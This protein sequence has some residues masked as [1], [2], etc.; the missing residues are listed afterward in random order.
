MIIRLYEDNPSPKHI[1]TIAKCLRDGGI[2]IYPTDT[3]YTFGCD[4]NKQKAIE[5][6]AKLK[7]VDPKKNNFSIVCESLSSASEFT[8]PI[9]NPTFKIMKRCLP[10]P[11]TFILNANSKLPKLFQ[12]KKKTVGIRIPNNAIVQDIIKELGNPILSASLHHKDKIIDY[13][14]DAELIYDEYKNK[15]DIVVNGGVGGNMPSTIVDCT[16]EENVIIREGLGDLSLI[17]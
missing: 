4:I 11:F 16:S 17:D 15:V 10:G 14:S 9:S 7:G 13:I 3:V 5:K 12:R 1:R 2:I 6:I 8:K